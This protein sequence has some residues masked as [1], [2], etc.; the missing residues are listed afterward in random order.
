[1]EVLEDS[2]C[3]EEKPESEKPCEQ[4]PCGGVDWI[5]SDWSGVRLDLRWVGGSWMVLVPETLIPSLYSSLCIPLPGC[6]WRGRELNN[7]C[8]KDT[9]TLSFF[10]CVC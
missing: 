2:Q 4:I 9:V 8:S 5:T 6:R 1:M 7:A 3:S 10:N